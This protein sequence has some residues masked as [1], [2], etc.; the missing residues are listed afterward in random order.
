[1]TVSDLL[2]DP[3]NKSD[4]INTVVTA[5]SKFVDNSTQAVRTLVDALLDLLQDA[6]F[7]RV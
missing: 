6:R 3:C 2:E 1:M 7:L 4:V 5:Y